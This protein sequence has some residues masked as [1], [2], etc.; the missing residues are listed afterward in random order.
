MCLWSTI[1]I[2]HDMQW[3][4]SDKILNWNLS[5]EENREINS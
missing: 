5:L 4:T 2:K 1:Y 3:S